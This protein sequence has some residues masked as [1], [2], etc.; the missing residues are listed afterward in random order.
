MGVAGSYKLAHKALLTGHAAEAQGHLQECHSLSGLLDL[1]DPGGCHLGS[2]S[3]LPNLTSFCQI[4]LGDR[5]CFA[6]P[7]R[8][9]LLLEGPFY[10][11]VLERF[12]ALPNC[13]GRIIVL[14]ICIGMILA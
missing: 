14:P 11:F 6:K 7:Y 2:K 10:H 1:D 12:I 5:N 9:I 13:I 4:D 3:C 8:V